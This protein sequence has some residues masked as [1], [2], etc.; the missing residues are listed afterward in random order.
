VPGLVCPECGEPA[1]SQPFCANCGRNLTREER[2]P[3]REEWEARSS[4]ARVQ[5]AATAFEPSAPGRWSRRGMVLATV[6]AVAAGAGIVALVLVLTSG[7]GTAGVPVRIP[8]GGMEP[9]LKIGQIVHVVQNASYVSKV[10]DVV[11]FHPPAGAD[12]ASATCGNPNQGASHQQPC[13]VPTSQES[14][15]LFIKRIVAGPG[16]TIAIV[17]GHVLRNGVR[18]SEPYIEACGGDPSCNFPSPITV[19]PGDY[20]VL[21]DNR[22]ASDDSR[23][24]GPVP[25][26]YIVGKV[27]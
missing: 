26:S 8:S 18:E 10:G 4:R 2:L 11:L 24:W 6:G 12:P 7:G 23:F 16:D 13:G 21:G 22:G 17:N 3:S 20:F 9:T 27:A 14:S 15:S 19:P 5:T 1:G 25:T